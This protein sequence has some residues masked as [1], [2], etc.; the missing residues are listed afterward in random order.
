MS[1]D[2][3]LSRVEHTE[4]A[5]APQL[6]GIDT[7]VGAKQRLKIFVPTPD[8]LFTVGA[9]GDHDARHEPLGPGGFSFRTVENLAAEIL[10]DTIVDTDGNT[11]I[12]T[13]LDFTTVAG[14]S[15]NLATNGTAQIGAGSTI[16]ITA[17]PSAGF[18]DPAFTVKPPMGVPPP[19]PIDT[20][21]DRSATE[22]GKT[23]FGL[24][25]LAFDWY[26]G[27]DS[28]KSIIKDRKLVKGVAVGTFAGKSEGAIKAYSTAAKLIDASLATWDAAVSA[29]ASLDIP[30][31]PD[32][33]PQQGTVAHGET[34]AHSA[35]P[36]VVVYGQDGIK[37][38]SPQ[39]ITAHASNGVGVSSQ[40]KVTIKA[41]VSA[42]M[43]SMVSSTV[44][45]IFSSKLESKFGVASV[46]GP[47]VSLKGK[48]HAELIAQEKLVISS[49]DFIGMAADH[50]VRISAKDKL[51][52][53]SE[54]AKLMATKTVKV[55]SD[56]EILVESAKVLKLNG[57]DTGVEMTSK[58]KIGLAVD[59]KSKVTMTPA[60]ISM[61]GGGGFKTMLNKTSFE[62]GN[63]NC[64]KTLTTIKGKIKLA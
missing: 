11:T 36:K 59:G 17:G 57:V 15:L 53:S 26:S 61:V 41:G 52:V 22:M 63:L 7:P 19:P 21:G 50:E 9:I 18:T 54:D 23:A 64:K 20:D 44:F 58:K 38:F 28:V 10:K 40:Y 13:K 3:Q 8:S 42:A 32:G 48:Q 37:M 25:W 6:P 45:S 24:A 43:K 62:T 51:E 5:H 30:E 12:H 1:D 39:Q 34:P 27:Y 47:I 14:N 16:T 55:L 35:H 4:E 2:S 60:S 31:P 49:H 29:V 33:H 56:E 46:T